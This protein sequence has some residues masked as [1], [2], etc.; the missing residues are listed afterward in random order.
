MRPLRQNA[1]R[2]RLLGAGLALLALWAL[3]GCDRDDA[4]A[5]ETDR[6]QVTFTADDTSIDAPA[7]VPSG[8]VDITL[9]TESGKLG[10]HIFVAR[11]EDG[12]SFEDAVVDGDDDAFFTKMTIKGGNGTI[13]AGKTAQ[14]TL[15]LEPGNYFVLDNPQNE[16]SPTDEFTVAAGEES[17]A[18]PD[19]KGT[20]HMGPGM[21]IDVPDDFDGRGVWEFINRDTEDVHEAAMVKLAAGKTGQDLVDW[22]HD[23]S[24]PPPIDGEFG[25]M[26]A[27]GPGQRAWMTL[28]P[29]EPGNYVVV[30]FVPGRDGIPHLAKGMFR[31]FEVR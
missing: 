9:R 26:G 3:A 27:L 18:Q 21:V 12:V 1:P 22:F 2:R 17:E 15:D 23:P 31:E 14:V 24:A 25:S 10:H 28:E 11:L 16:E 4:A 8:L 13:A 20:V 30:C 6:P 29:G 5:A 19:A 7:D